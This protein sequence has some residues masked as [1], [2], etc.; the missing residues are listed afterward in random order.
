MPC[1]HHL[2]ENVGHGSG[3]APAADQ[4]ERASQ[5]KSGPHHP[6]QYYS[7]DATIGFMARFKPVQANAKKTTRPQGAAGCLS[8]IV[9]IMVGVMVFLYLVMKSN[10]NANG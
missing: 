4:R 8:L 7:H 10:G 3:S 1:T 5:Q 2:R 6:S 9:L